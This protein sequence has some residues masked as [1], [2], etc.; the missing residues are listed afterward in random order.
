[1]RLDFYT[2]PRPLI[3]LLALFL[4]SSATVSADPFPAQLQGLS[5]QQLF[6]RG[7][8]AVPCGWQGQLCCGTG[9]VCYTDA[10]SQAQCS[11]TAG[12]VTATAAAAGG[13]GYWNVYT[14][15]Y[16]ESELTTVTS[17]ISSWCATTTACSSSHHCGFI[18]CILQLRQQRKSLRKHLLRE[19]SVLR[20]FRSMRS[21]CCQW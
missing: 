6:G 12:V 20:H 11:K 10:N 21:R 18:V 7:S 8:C 19:R 5:F 16:V 2:M 14:T 15:T 3:Q 9:E 1:M 13:N 4:A 17:V